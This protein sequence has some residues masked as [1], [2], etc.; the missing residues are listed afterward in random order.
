MSPSKPAAVCLN[1]CDA[2]WQGSSR[3]RVVIIDFGF[4]ELSPDPDDPARVSDC[5]ALAEL[6]AKVA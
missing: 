3:P 6:L 1:P 4:A 5:K 2:A